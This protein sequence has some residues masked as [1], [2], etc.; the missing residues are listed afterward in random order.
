[1]KKLTPAFARMNAI[2][3]ELAA[4]EQRQADTKAAIA[5]IRSEA[6]AA[7]VQLADLDKVTTGERVEALI[8]GKGTVSTSDAA[9]KK[10][11]KKATLQQQVADLGRDLT[12]LEAAGAECEATCQQLQDEHSRLHLQVLQTIHDDLCDQYLEKAKAFVVDAIVPLAAISR[13]LG[14]YS[15]KVRGNNGAAN[16]SQSLL[17]QVEIGFWHT[18]HRSFEKLMGGIGGHPNLHHI[19]R[20]AVRLYSPD[21][22]P[23]LVNR[24]IE[25]AQDDALPNEEAQEAE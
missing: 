22:Y 10:A 17:G 21:R 16:R 25:R 23:E 11:Q 12:L 19:S 1:M 20:E 15:H 3:G 4:V 2:Q 14:S 13:V 6:A 18:E 7:Q 8:K 5:K 9:S 24:M